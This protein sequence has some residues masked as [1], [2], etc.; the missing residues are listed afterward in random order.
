MTKKVLLI[1][2]VIFISITSFA[3]RNTQKIG[4]VDME[5]ILENIPDYA[6]AQSQLNEKAKKWQ[7]NLDKL[8]GEI[9]SMK[10][11]LSNEK[12]LLT[13][14]LI[15]EKEEDIEIKVEEFKKLES[16]YFSSNGDLFFY[17]KQLVKPIQDQ[18]YNAAQEIGKARGFD[19]IFDKSSDLI[20]L[21]TN[22]K[23]DIS[24]L[25]LKSIVRTEKTEQAKEKRSK[26]DETTVQPKEV[27]EEV[28]KKIDAREAKRKELLERAEKLKAAKLKKREEQ[29]AAI[30]KKRL[31]RLKKQE[32]VRNKLKQNKKDSQSKKEDEE[33]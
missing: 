18:V 13:E 3:Q 31:E 33:E 14:D 22:S 9:E 26:K 17:R 23:L 32:E 15:A 30:E 16:D 21:Y 24:E 5:Y 10:A 27:N 7:Q 25:V 19:V 2:V 6:E 29:K 28:Q 11:D 20:M 1:V 4:Y 8:K 12:A